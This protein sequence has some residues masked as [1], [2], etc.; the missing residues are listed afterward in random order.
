[1]KP[2]VLV[3]EDEKN[4]VKVLKYNL[5]NEGY[6]VSVATD[7]QAGLDALRKE[8]P[9]LVIL[10]IMLPKLDGYEFLKRARQAGD[11][12]IM[13]LTARKEEVDRILGLELGADDYITK[14]FSVRE[15]M[16]R[17]KTVLR[18]TKSVSSGGGFQ[19]GGLEIDLERY[20][21]RVK[22]QPVD[23]TTSEFSFLRCLIE[24]E[25]KAMTRDAILEGMRGAEKAL[26]LDPHAIDQQVAR[27]RAKLG[28]EAARIVTVKNIGYR[29]K[30]G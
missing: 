25:G 13:I 17:I 2:L 10:D 11:T 15:V 14:P 23:L 20:E 24:A 27:L 18:R 4:I 21:A 5:E 22:G 7:G 30:I 1:M 3:V 28:S 19:T 8:K 16:A 12:P 9:S 26:E 6:R 29:I